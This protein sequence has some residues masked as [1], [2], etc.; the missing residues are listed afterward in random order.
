MGLTDQCPGGQDGV[1][2]GATPHP[3][4][5]A[6]RHRVSFL[7]TL[8]CVVSQEERTGPHGGQHLLGAA[9]GVGA[10]GEGPLR[11]LPCP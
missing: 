11:P 9:E 4:K 8:V 3:P 10:L 1:P 6:E 7:C 2:E 5:E